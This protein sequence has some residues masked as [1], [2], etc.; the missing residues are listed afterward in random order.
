MA[1][2]GFITLAVYEDAN[3]P[4]YSQVNIA[5][6][7][8]LTAS[9]SGCKFLKFEVTIAD[10]AVTYSISSNVLTFTNVP[11]PPANYWP[12]G[13]VNEYFLKT[14]YAAYFHPDGGAFPDYAT[15]P[16]P[17]LMLANAGAI[18]TLP[19]VAKEG[20]YLKGYYTASSGGTF[21]GMPGDTYNPNAAAQ[22]TVNLY[23]Q[24]STEP[25]SELILLYNTQGGIIANGQYFKRVARFS[26]YGTLATPTK[27]GYTFA[28]W[29][30]AATGGTQVSSSTVVSLGGT[31]TI[32][33]HWTAQSVY[34]TVTFDAAGGSVTTASKQVLINSAIGTLP[35]ATRSGYTFAGWKDGD[36]NAISASTVVSERNLWVYAQWTGNTYTLT[37]NANGGSVSPATKSCNVG[38]PVGDLPT[39]TRSQYAFQGWF[40]SASGGTEVTAATVLSASATLYAHWSQNSVDWWN[41]EIS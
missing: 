21:V 24:W 22:A 37:F 25:V 41:F 39:P 30:T 17:L 27:D 5:T 32:Y 13:T 14:G 8:K 29:W 1:N 7:T 10:T 16:T 11:T 28:G 38:T 12:Y 4:T 3:L 6:G 23:C 2:T 20:Y 40:T 26:S 33:A 36:G 18:L 19:N 15:H 34:V 31:K 9:R 35:T